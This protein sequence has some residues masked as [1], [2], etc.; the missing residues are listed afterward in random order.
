[1]I[2]KQINEGGYGIIYRGK[3]RES[4]VAIKVI[5]TEG[6]SENVLRDFLSECHAMEVSI[7][8]VRR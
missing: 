1:M 6:L 7:N 5:K 3:W 4:V 2:E 8:L